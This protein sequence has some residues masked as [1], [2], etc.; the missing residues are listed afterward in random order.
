MVKDYL[1]MIVVFEG[2]EVSV[3]SLTESMSFSDFDSWVRGRFNVEA[4]EKLVYRNK[5][6]EEIIP[7]GSVL[8]MSIYL[9]RVRAVTPVPNDIKK[10]FI[11]SLLRSPNWLLFVFLVPPV[12]VLL[13]AISLATNKSSHA[14]VWIPSQICEKFLGSDFRRLCSNLQE[15]YIAFLTWSFTYLFIRRWANPETTVGAFQKYA[16]DAIFGGLAAGIACY[17]KISLRAAFSK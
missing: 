15:A 5:N 6:G 11:S 7:G 16:A 13:M 9:E 4:N 8:C 10:D 12:L 17:L 1:S 3:S 14:V 2:I